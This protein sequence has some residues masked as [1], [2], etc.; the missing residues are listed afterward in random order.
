[1]VGLD[2]VV[3]GGYFI[4]MVGIG[5][6]AKSRIHDAADF[7]AAGGKMPWWLS[8]ISHH[9]SG[10]S[11]VVFVVAAAI[12]YTEGLVLYVWWALGISFA[13]VA[14][15]FLFAPRWPRLRQRL[16]VVSPLEY[17][18]I[19]YNLPTQQLLAWSGTALKVF[20]VGAKWTATALLLNVFAG[21]PLAWGILLTGGVTLVY[22]TIGG[23]WADA[24]TD[25]GQFLI[26]LVAGVVMFVAALARLGGVSALWTMWGD[27]PEGNTKPF[28]GQYTLLFVLVY[29]VINTLSYNGGTWNLAQ[30]FIASPR[31]STARKAALFSAALY[32]FWPLVMFF[33][34]WAGPILLPNLDDPQQ[35]YALLTQ[36][37]LPAGLVGLVLAGLF[38]HTMA[39]TGSDA[40]AISAVVTRDILPAV[41]RGVRGVASGTELVIGR[42][43]VF[44]FIALSIV[45]ALT[46]DSFGGVLG[47]IILWFGGLV[48]PIAIPMLLGLLPAFKRCGPAAAVTSWTTGVVTF[49]ATRYVIDGWVGSLAPDQV[50]AVQ[51]GGPVGVALLTYVVIG[52]VLPWHNTRSDELIDALGADGDDEQPRESAHAQPA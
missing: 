42:V 20:D 24:L 17:L 15:A 6:W 25:M 50:T 45:I 19:R 27:L 49:V 5:F 40:N 38:S 23:L 4:V 2:W 1:M 48:G 13:M 11:G 10:Y 52:W 33:P 16:N 9:M 3:V 32:L 37:L 44:T 21:V 34:M 36:N 7:F 26:Q 18:K 12:A 41:W 29:L 46:A 51:V 39:M 8:G 47:L 22:S 43:G 28:S 35:S 31:G 14:G 30:R